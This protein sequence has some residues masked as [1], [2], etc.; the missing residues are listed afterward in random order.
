[1][2][3]FAPSPKS[4][5]QL[6]IVPALAVDASEKTT[7]RSA[8]EVETMLYCAVGKG[9]ITMEV[10]SVSLTHPLSVMVYKRIG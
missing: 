10:A 8:Q 5:H 2:F 4:H 7:A 1:M 9:L 6:L 3:S